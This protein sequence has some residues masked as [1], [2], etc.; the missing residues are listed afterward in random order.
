MSYRV[1]TDKVLFV[2]PNVEFGVIPDIIRENCA[3]ARQMAQ[4]G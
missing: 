1:S 3:F 4:L 2:T